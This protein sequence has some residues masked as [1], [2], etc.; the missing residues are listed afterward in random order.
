MSRLHAAV[1]RLAPMAALPARSLGGHAGERFADR[2][3]RMTTSR[4]R[5]HL[6]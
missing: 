6:H 1:P 4:P 3:S 5:S 2:P